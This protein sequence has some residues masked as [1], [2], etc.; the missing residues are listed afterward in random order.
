MV[1]LF[2]KFSLGI[3]FGGIAYLGFSFVNPGKVEASHGCTH[4]GVYSCL[5]A[6]IRDGS[7][8]GP[9]LNGAVVTMAIPAVKAG[10]FCSAPGKSGTFAA[11][12]TNSSGEANID[13]VCC[14]SVLTG[15]I[16]VMVTKSGYI[17]WPPGVN[18]ADPNT[19]A[20]MNFSNGA[21]RSL[22]I[23]LVPNAPPVTNRLNINSSPISVSMSGT[24]SG[25][26]P[27]PQVTSSSNIN[28]SEL[29]PSSV[30]GY[31]F[32][33]WSGCNSVSGTT[34]NVTVSGGQSKTV[35]ANYDPIV[36]GTNRLNVNSSG[37]SNVPI[38]GTY[39]DNTNFSRTSASAMNGTL[40]APSSA[41]GNAFSFWGGCTSSSGNNCTYSVSGGG[42]QT[43][44]ANYA[45]PG[46][47]VVHV[48][49]T[50][51]GV[52]NSG[53]VIS[54]GPYGGSTP[55][56]IPPAPSIGGTINAQSPSCGGNFSSWSGCNWVGPLPSQCNIFPPNGSTMTVTAN[57]TSVVL[58]TP[59]PTPISGL[60]CVPISS[61]YGPAVPFSWSTVSG[62]TSY[63]VQ[64]SIYSQQ[65]PAGNGDFVNPGLGGYYVYKYSI[66]TIN[67]TGA[68]GWNSA[69]GMPINAANQPLRLNPGTTYYWHVRAKNSS[70]T[71]SW[72]NL[73]SFSA[74]TCVAR[75]D[76]QIIA[77]SASGSMV[78][79]APVSITATLWNSGTA[80]TT[81]GVS[82]YNDAVVTSPVGIP[83][84]IPDSIKPAISAWGTQLL[85][86][87]W[88]PTSAGSY[89]IQL[90]AD[91]SVLNP[92]RNNQIVESDE[93]DA[94][95]CKNVS[96]SVS[97]TAPWV[98]TEN[99]NVG[100]R[101]NPAISKLDLI[102]GGS[103]N[104][105]YI[106]QKGPLATISN[107]FE[108][109]K[110]W[111]VNS[112]P[113][114]KS[115]NTYEGL[116]KELSPSA[117]C[118]ITSATTIPDQRG[119]FIKTSNLAITSIPTG[120][121]PGCATGKDAALIFVEGNLDINI[122]LTPSRPTAFIVSGYVHVASNVTTINATLVNDRD[123]TDEIG[124]R[125]LT[126]N[127]SIISALNSIPTDHVYLRRKVVG[128]GDPLGDYLSEHIILQPSYFYY[129]TDY[130]GIANTTY[131]EENP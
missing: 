45:S 101:S 47:T 121:I 118:A 66:A 23:Y 92:I 115:P 35:T 107:F 99:G 7:S 74:A 105:D 26:T 59:T 120:S 53:C 67:T 69:G 33:S 36:V 43:V 55:Y 114:P 1:K 54:G 124:D 89:T 15:T 106:I 126:V 31:N 70:S 131:K 129:L 6:H 13:N 119:K 22:D 109:A 113:D 9:G 21:S 30:P 32:S 18:T 127:G 104:A 12:T 4:S 94:S 72:S 58:G 98:R 73:G 76:L 86:W 122:N 71:G 88:T 60:P 116:K 39:T 112:I 42:T 96:F 123:F 16:R 51:N 87:S 27:L 128:A 3:F 48:Q 77:A 49:S 56:T 52:A 29:A 37:A 20:A 17:A 85:S 78:V 64:V 63:D 75:P 81:V 8:S 61:T 117:S 38:T 110:N 28:A 79:G 90:C 91:R 44:T 41:S 10:F 34:C 93:S 68:S 2:F 14:N 11:D 65:N 103:S 82:I 19:W 50:L 102:V 5:Q 111:V 62:A 46:S 80:A 130:A 57:Y 95:N 25:N 24:Y 97:A 83:P 108:S 40:T 125:K 84:S 100:S